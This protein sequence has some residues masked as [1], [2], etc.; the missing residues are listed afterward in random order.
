M[1]PLLII[2]LIPVYL[3]VIWYIF[4]ESP[5]DTG[6]PTKPISWIGWYVIAFFFGIIPMLL[7]LSAY[8]KA[9]GNLERKNENITIEEDISNDKN[10]KNHENK[11]IELTN[12]F[13]KTKIPLIWVIVLF[14]I[15]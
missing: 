10:I 15:I 2:I 9:R 12:I 1:D 11:I 3:I 6:D 7:V 8:C 4:Y 5:R 13:L 14:V